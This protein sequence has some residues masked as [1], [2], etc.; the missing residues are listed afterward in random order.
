LGLTRQTPLSDKVNADIEPKMPCRAKK[1]IEN[2]SFFM[3]PAEV[4][5]AV[6]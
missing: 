5:L 2:S 6:N 1:E 4:R 3:S